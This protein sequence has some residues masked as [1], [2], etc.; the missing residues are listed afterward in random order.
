MNQRYIE[1]KVIVSY[2]VTI[3]GRNEDMQYLKVQR[4]MSE[5]KNL[6]LF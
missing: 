1:L 5:D 3:S 4:T 6:Y 2:K